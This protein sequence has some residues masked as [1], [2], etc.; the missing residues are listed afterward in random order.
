MKKK[1]VWMVALLCCIILA[2]FVSK[3]GYQLMIIQG[4]SMEPTYH[5]LQMVVINRWDKSY[6]EG[7]VI[8][9]KCKGL[10]AV[11]VKRIA[12]RRDDGYYVLGDN[13][14]ESIDSRDNRVGIVAENDIIGKLVT[15]KRNSY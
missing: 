5:N 2:F 3:Y 12:Q 11:L 15:N 10:D 4:K 6:N 7:D 14:L 9:F 8:V 1:N 13:S